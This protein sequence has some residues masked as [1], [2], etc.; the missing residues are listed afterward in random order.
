MAQDDYYQL[1]GVR[2]GASLAEIKRAFRSRV[3]ETHP[4][5]HPDSGLANETTRSLIEAYKVLTDPSR[6]KFYDLS[7]APYVPSI[8]A[9]AYTAPSAR[10]LAALRYLRVVV[11]VVFLFGAA[12][13]LAQAISTDSTKGRTYTFSN[14]DS[15]RVDEDEMPEWEPVSSQII[16]VSSAQEVKASPALTWSTFPPLAAGGFQPFSLHLNH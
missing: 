8:A 4:D 2:K 1:L 11:A 16:S 3:L 12:L 14:I 7:T 9:V 13:C 10:A 15:V 5:H 6:R